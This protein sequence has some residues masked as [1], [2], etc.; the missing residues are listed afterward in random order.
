M[1]S[2][3]LT[4]MLYCKLCNDPLNVPSVNFM[5]KN[6]FLIEQYPRITVTWTAPSLKKGLSNWN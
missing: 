4:A 5:S 6:M 3:M 1:G 2:S